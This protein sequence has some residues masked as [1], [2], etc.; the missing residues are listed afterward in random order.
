MSPISTAPAAHGGQ[1]SSCTLAG[2]QN[3][4][5]GWSSRRSPSTAVPWAG[6]RYGIGTNQQMTL[7]GHSWLT[8]QGTWHGWGEQVTDTGIVELLAAMPCLRHL[9]PTNTK[10]LLLLLL[11]AGLTFGTCR[12]QEVLK[13]L[14]FSPSSSQDSV[15][16]C[17]SQ[18]RSWP[19]P[20]GYSVPDI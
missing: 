14:G 1:Q 6:S 3:I 9:S 8:G 18:D 19:G 12:A 4:I 10:L 7:Q 13:Y 20:R 2:A 5:V 16:F 15:N 11:G 17:S